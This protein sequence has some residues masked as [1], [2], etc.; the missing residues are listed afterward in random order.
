MYQT[1]MYRHLDF[2]FSCNFSK[3]RQVLKEL[4]IKIA[5]SIRSL[6]EHYNFILLSCDVCFNTFTFLFHMFWFTTLMARIMLCRCFNLVTLKRKYQN[7]SNWCLITNMTLL[8][9]HLKKII[10]GERFCIICWIIAVRI[11]SIDMKDW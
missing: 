9:R 8:H 2:T 10:N 11:I 5:P 3:Y 7:I 4:E 6:K 1:K